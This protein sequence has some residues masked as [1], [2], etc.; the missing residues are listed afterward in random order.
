MA[1]AGVATEASAVAAAVA[2]A[3]AAAAW[4]VEWLECALLPL[5]AG[6]RSAADME[7]HTSLVMLLD[8]IKDLQRLLVTAPVKAPPLLLAA[9]CEGL[10]L[11]A[12]APSGEMAGLL[13][14]LGEVLVS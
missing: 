9:P 11:T 3:A 1:A 2:A 10:P 13:L 6:V 8:G 14:V 5:L 4:S 7:V 12:A